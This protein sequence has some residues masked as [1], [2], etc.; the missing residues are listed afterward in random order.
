MVYRSAVKRKQRQ[1]PE[2]VLD[3]LVKLILD[4]NLLVLDVFADQIGIGDDAAFD[5]LL[6]THELAEL[7]LEVE[8]IA[9][10]GFQIDI[11][12]AFVNN[13]EEFIDIHIAKRPYCTHNTSSFQ[14]NDL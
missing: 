12:L 9:L 5:E 13:G 11:T 1:E 6:K 7:A 3:N 2:S 10:I 8:L 14:I 4:K